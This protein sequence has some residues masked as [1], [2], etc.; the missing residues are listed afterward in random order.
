FW[1]I[2]N[3]EFG[4]MMNIQN[5]PSSPSSPSSPPLP[6]SASP[7]PRVF[8]PPSPDVGSTI[9]TVLSVDRDESLSESSV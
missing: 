2:R 4:K 6:L 7:R 9:E 8:F 5:S 3:S 1:G